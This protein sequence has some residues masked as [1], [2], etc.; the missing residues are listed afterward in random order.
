MGVTALPYVQ[1]P[2]MPKIEP[3]QIAETKPSEI[4]VTETLEAIRADLGECTRCP[5]HRGRNHIVFG[6]GPATARVMF[7]GEGPG[8][9]EDIQGVPFVG[10]AGQ[11]LTDIIV[12]G[13][14]LRREDCYIGNIVK[15]RPPQNRD[16]HPDEANTCLPFLK[17]QIAA[18]RP[19]VIVALGRVAAHYLLTQDLPLARLRHRFHDFE[20]I[21]VMPTYHP[22]AL[23]RDPRR[24]RDTWE[25]IK[26]VLTKLDL[27]A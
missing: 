18:I 20:G 2:D 11:L 10:A 1:P 8:R 25:D 21:P 4:T 24:K 19:E 23:L 27:P 15:C 13:M 9:D 6:E 3:P 5:L 7:V 12:K 26:L 17:R 14:K 16:P 22:A